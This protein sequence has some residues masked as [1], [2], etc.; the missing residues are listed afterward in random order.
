MK[1]GSCLHDLVAEYRRS[2]NGRDEIMEGIASQVYAN[3]RRFGFDGEDE[4]ADALFR[5]GRRIAS[6][7]DRFV[8][9][10]L[11]FDA[12]LVTSLRFLSRTVRRNRRREAERQRVCERAEAELGSQEPA[13]AGPGLC[14][15]PPEEADKPGLP[16]KRGKRAETFA[17]RL[18]FLYL[19]CA[20]DADDSSTRRVAAAAHVDF[21]WL[22]S[23]IAQAR[24]SLDTERARFERMAT[25]RNRSWCR[26][27]ILE[28]RLRDEAELS[29]R[30]GLQAAVERERSRFERAREGLR[31]FRPV[32]PNSMVA[33]ILDVPKGTVDSGL[34]YFKK[35]R[36]L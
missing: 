3:P 18:V 17:S 35:A 36:G 25:G 6:L 4:A 2:G 26:L 9:R 33:R 16:R 30:I 31:L 21:D 15:D 12:Y 22:N 14:Y 23:A 5:Y 8:D 13:E 1:T 28:A 10:G 7:A 19:K 34:Y 29:R 27:R 20:W 24:R 32:V 11:P